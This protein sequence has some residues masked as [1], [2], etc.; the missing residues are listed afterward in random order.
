MS[1]YLAEKT[2]KHAHP[3]VNIHASP[4]A[5]FW[6]ENS[7]AFWHQNKMAAFLA[8]KVDLSQIPKS[9]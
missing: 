1:T 5:S 7:G 4:A 9:D 8:L 3:T 2:D 6:Q